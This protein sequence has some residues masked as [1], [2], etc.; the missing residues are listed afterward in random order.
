[1]CTTNCHPSHLPRYPWPCCFQFLIV[2]DRSH[3]NI[4]P[5]RCPKL[6]RRDRIQLQC[7]RRFVLYRG[8]QLR[9]CRPFHQEHPP[10]SWCFQC[11]TGRIDSGPNTSHRRC[12]R[13]RKKS[14]RQLKH[15]PQFD[16]YLGQPLRDCRRFYLPHHPWSWYFQFPTGRCCSIPNTSLNHHRELH[17]CEQNL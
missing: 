8:Q 10:W 11:P 6:H 9:G 13:E 14:D 2:R 3:P 1:M 5:A 7:Q 12:P 17:R 15:Q 4:W 16:L